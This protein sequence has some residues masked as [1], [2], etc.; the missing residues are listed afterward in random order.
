M[1]FGIFLIS[2]ALAWS[3]SVS[4]GQVRQTSSDILGRFLPGKYFEWKAQFY[5]KKKDYGIARQLA[6]L[7][8]YWGDKTAQYNLGIMYYNGIGMTADKARGAAWL[9]IAAE[10]HNP[11]AIQTLGLANAELTPQ[12]HAAADTIWQELEKKYGDTVTLPRVRANFE[13]ER[14]NVTG[15]R[16]GA[17]GNMKVI[18]G[19]PGGSDKGATGSDFYANQQAEFDEYIETNFGQ[20][21][22][23]V[24]AIEPVAAPAENA[25]DAAKNIPDTLPLK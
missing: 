16:V 20:G 1:R 19:G 4:A 12:Q 14:R 17:V 2:V 9:R 5:L 7:A 22:V 15:S 8:S 11:L 24:G 6:D 21:H 13:T 10:A 23:D 18:Y 3:A 25:H